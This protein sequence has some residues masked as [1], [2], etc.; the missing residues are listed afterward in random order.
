MARRSRGKQWEKSAQ[1]SAAV[2]RNH[3]TDKV[4]RIT[5]KATPGG[6]SSCSEGRK[7]G[8]RFR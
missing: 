8:P 3:K 7:A 6:S 2:V 5:I 1:E 4:S